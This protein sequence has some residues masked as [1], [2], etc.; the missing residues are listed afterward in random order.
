MQAVPAPSAGKRMLTQRRRAMVEK[1][2]F[3]CNS[4]HR[5][6]YDEV[7][8]MLSS[9]E[10]VEKPS[11]QNECHPEDAEHRTIVVTSAWA[12]QGS[13]L[14]AGRMPGGYRNERSR[15]TLFRGD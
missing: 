14:A 5:S 4:G 7:H 12:S 15:C 9:R 8:T 6:L 1:R 3:G 10:T 11:R 2:R 13:I